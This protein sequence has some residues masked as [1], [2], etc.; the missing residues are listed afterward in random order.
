MTQNTHITVTLSP[1]LRIEQA[2]KQAGVEDPATITH[3]TVAG[4]LSM[5]DCKYIRENMSKTLHILDMGSA[6]MKRCIIGKGAFQHCNGLT[7]VTIPA[8]VVGIDEYAFYG[9]SFVSISIPSSVKK[10]GKCAFGNCSNLTSVYI[11]ASVTEIGYTA[12]YSDPFFTS[13]HPDKPDYSEKMTSVSLIDSDTGIAE[14]LFAV[15]HGL[16]SISVHPDNTAYADIN[17]VL[18]NKDKTRLIQYPA[19]RKD[20][21]YVIPDSVTTIDDCAFRCCNIISVTIPDSVTEIGS[22]AFGECEFGEYALESLHIPASVTKIGENIFESIYYDTAQTFVTVHPDN[23]V[24]T[25]ENG[26]LKYKHQ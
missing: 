4:V 25:A 11:P 14:R 6:S 23:P 3:L 1:E 8:S 24:Y 17:G 18:F 9:C 16:T 13:V 21:N 2:L 5:G 19:G 20:E 12:F 26:E 7:S 15:C 22:G 10:I